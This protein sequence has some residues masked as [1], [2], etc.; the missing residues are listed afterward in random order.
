MSRK[1]KKR[2]KIN[3]SDNFASCCCRLHVMLCRQLVSDTIALSDV[4]AVILFD[5][6][7]GKKIEE[8]VCFIEPLYN[9]IR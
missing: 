8:C 3:L 5:L 4:W 9:I 7:E 1:K 2:H 6:G